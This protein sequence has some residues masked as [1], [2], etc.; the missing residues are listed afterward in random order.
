MDILVWA[1]EGNHH[2]QNLFHKIYNH[3]TIVP[4]ADIIIIY[5]VYQV[6]FQVLFGF[7][8]FSQLDAKPFQYCKNMGNVLVNPPNDVD[9]QNQM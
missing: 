8:F 5:Y 2:I 7:N 1:L 9:L 3:P 6:V 4:N